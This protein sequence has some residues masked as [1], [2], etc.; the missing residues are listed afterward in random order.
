MSPACF[1][2]TEP[3]C[4]KLFKIYTSSQVSTTRASEALQSGINPD[5]EIQEVF[6]VYLNKFENAVAYLFLVILG[7]N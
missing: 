3:V 4:F 6:Y 5:T 7:N 1:R 2:S